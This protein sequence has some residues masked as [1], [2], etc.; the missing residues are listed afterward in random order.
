VIESV[1]HG[2]VLELRLARPPVNALDPGLL[3]EIRRAV[4]SAPLEGARAVVL[5]GAPGLFCAGLDVPALAVLDRP[6]LEEG[7][8]S[9]FGVMFDLATSVVPVAAAVTGHSPAGGAILAMFCD[10][11]VM[12]EGAFGI[13]LTEVQVGIPMPRV[14]AGLAR[15]VVGPREAELMCVTGQLMNPGDAAALGLVDEVAPPDEV[16][17]RAVAWCRDVV[18]RPA[19]AVTE[20]RKTMR[21]D[22]VNLVNTHRE[23]DVQ[24]LLDE[25]F[26]PEMQKT[27]KQFVERLKSPK[28]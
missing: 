8:K 26:K 5:S 15:R 19:R 18:A 22:L 17:D 11:R 25:W 1:H 28:R 2:E 16:V 13:G 24:Y 4:S 7:L 12:A 20:T 14:V 23:D 3:K 21:Q 9:F 27:L 10:F 6:R